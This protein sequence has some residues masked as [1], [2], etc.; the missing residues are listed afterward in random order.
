MPFSIPGC[1]MDRFKLSFYCYVNKYDG[2]HTHKIY[3]ESGQYA[4]D[5]CNESLC[6]NQTVWPELGWIH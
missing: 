4:V 3:D 1:V 6:N 5:C 2:R